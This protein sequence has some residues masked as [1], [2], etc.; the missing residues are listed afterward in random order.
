MMAGADRGTWFV[1]ELD[2]EVLVGFGAGDPDHP[3]VIGALW[4]GEGPA[5]GDA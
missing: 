2:D 5:A 1:P 4:N 3:Y